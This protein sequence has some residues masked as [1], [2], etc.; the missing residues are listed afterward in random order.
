MGPHN[1]NILIAGLTGDPGQCAAAAGAGQLA[2]AVALYRG[3]LAA[4][5]EKEQEHGNTLAAK[6]NLANALS[7]L[8]D[9]AGGEA[10]L[11]GV[12]A[13]QK[14][15][16][17]PDDAQT[18]QTA[19]L[20]GRTLQDQGRYADAVTI[21]RPTLAAQQRVLGPL[22]PDTLSTMHNLAWS[23]GEQGNYVEAEP[24][25][26][27]ALER[28]RRTLGL[29]HNNTLNNAQ[30]WKARRGRGL[31]ER[32][33]GGAWVPMPP[34]RSG[35]STAWRFAGTVRASMRRRRGCC[36]V[37]WGRSGA[38]KGRAMGT[39]WRRLRS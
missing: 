33:G 12:K 25:F 23:L 8:D 29:N 22:H 27:S 16:R 17:G 35:S 28:R 3:L 24:R 20:L 34:A 10:L 38:P 36:S 5:P 30:P 18:L 13:T 37:C 15:L 4:T 26:Q 1:S 31:G 39:R 21:Y 6:G 19:G 9:H 32:R 14:R 7:D 2:D 11:R